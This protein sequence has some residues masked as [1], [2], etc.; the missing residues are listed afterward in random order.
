MARRARAAA[1]ANY[2][3]ETQLARFDQVIAAVLQPLPRMN[4]VSAA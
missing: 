2:R 4:P 3:W 1:E